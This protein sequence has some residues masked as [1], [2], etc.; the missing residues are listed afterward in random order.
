M[1]LELLKKSLDD[2]FGRELK[3]SISDLGMSIK[4][5]SKR[6]D[7]PESTLYKIISGDRNDYRI[8]TL[9]KIINTVKEIEGYTE[10][11]TIGIIT[12]RGALDSIKREMKFEDKVIKIKEFP[13][14]T[15]EEEIIQGVRAEKE[16]IKGLVCGPLAAT[17]LEKVVDIPVTALKFEE[18]PLYNSIE[19]LGRK[20]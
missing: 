17:T 3:E 14:T 1:W 2:D 13:A 4:E 19:R 16:G 8:S 9:K 18:G 5:F 20:I 6:A 7:I 11:N 12:S 10:H 15:I